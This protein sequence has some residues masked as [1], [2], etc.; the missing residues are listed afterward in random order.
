MW[1]LSSNYP[2]KP[3]FYVEI[4]LCHGSNFQMRRIYLYGNS[5]GFYTHAASKNKDAA[6]L[7]VYGQRRRNE[8]IYE[9]F[10]TDICQKGCKPK[11]WFR[12]RILQ[13][14]YSRYAKTDIV[15]RGR[16]M[17][18]QTMEFIPKWNYFRSYM[19]DEI[20]IDDF[21]AK[22]KNIQT[23]NSKD[24][25]GKSLQ[26]TVCRPENDRGL[27]YDNKEVSSVDS[28]GSDCSSASAAGVTTILSIFVYNSFDIGILS[29]WFAGFSSSECFKKIRRHP[30]QHC[31]S[32]CS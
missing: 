7:E 23:Y 21:C 26:G 18:P 13:K 17:L 19:K 29:E 32:L 6:I 16:P 9:A 28:L 11:K 24:M 5:W 30:C 14:M 25:Y 1:G 15:V 12:T 4:K 22:A 10:T 2:D 3:F 27:W 31:A 20:T 8:S